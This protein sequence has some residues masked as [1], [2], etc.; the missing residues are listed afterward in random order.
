MSSLNQEQNCFKLIKIR[1]LLAKLHMDSLASES[2]PRSLRRALDSLPDGLDKTYDEAVLRIQSR[3][4]TKD[5][6]NK[7]LSWVAF[8][9]RPLTINELRYALAIEKDD[10]HLDEEALPK[11]DFLLSVCGGL[12]VVD[13]SEIVRFIHFTAQDYFARACHLG[14]SSAHNYLAT[15]CIT[16]LS[17][18]TFGIGPCWVPESTAETKHSW[19]KYEE[20]LNLVRKRL[21]DNVLLS[22]VSVHWGD[23]VRECGNQDYAI[24]TSTLQ[25]LKRKPN[26]S[27]SIE[28]ACCLGSS[29]WYLSGGN[30]FHAIFL[31]DVAELH[32]AAGFGLEKLTEDLLQQGVDI[33]AQDSNGWTSLHI[34][35]ANGHINVIKILLGKGANRSLRTRD[36]YEAVYLAAI[37]GHES[38]TS[39][40]LNKLPLLPNTKELI[41]EVAWRGHLEV[42]RCLLKHL[43]TRKEAL[44]VE[45]YVSRYS[46]GIE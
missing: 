41:R 20:V 16:Y 27:C 46:R 22:Y 23:H 34:A 36:E 39:L 33:D 37:G 4:T 12:I 40:L 43:G 7:I 44:C 35:S 18:S 6:V 29:P 32:V 2:S 13:E 9:Q 21:Q 28:T 19:S 26:I 31:K 45:I 14:L 25:L 8:A 5:F 11:A 38:A 24:H 3:D 42:L 1:F 15:V 30:P 10:S 17:F